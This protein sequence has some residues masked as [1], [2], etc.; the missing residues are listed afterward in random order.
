MK[1]YPRPAVELSNGPRH[2]FDR[3]GRGALGCHCSR[4]EIG[5]LNDAATTEGHGLGTS[6][7][8]GCSHAA[9]VPGGRA[10]R[11][12]HPSIVME[13]VISGWIWQK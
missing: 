13:P 3:R 11:V 6:A 10:G 12:A 4:A 2:D 7:T 5:I 9:A 8:E 1:R